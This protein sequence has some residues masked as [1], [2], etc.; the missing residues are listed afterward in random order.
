MVKVSKPCPKHV[1]HAKNYSTPTDLSKSH[2]TTSHNSEAIVIDNAF[3]TLH[4]R[5]FAGIHGRVMASLE[6]V[7]GMSRVPVISF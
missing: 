4:N 6:D 1:V 3:E 2:A 7:E 5:N